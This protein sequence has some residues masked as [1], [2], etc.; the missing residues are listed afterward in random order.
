MASEEEEEEEEDELEDE[1]A[2][3][4][5]DAGSLLGGEGVRARTSTTLNSADADDGAAEE[6]EE[7]AFV[8]FTAPENERLATP[9]D[10]VTGPEGGDED[11]E[12]GTASTTFKVE[13]INDDVDEDNDGVNA[14]DVPSG[15]A[16]SEDDIVVILNWAV[17]GCRHG[18]VNGC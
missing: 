10:S 7:E 9:S 11:L 3:N 4:E 15:E 6:E 18:K 17:G 2:I 13:G 8:E 14:E 1:A 12:R 16:E 5:L